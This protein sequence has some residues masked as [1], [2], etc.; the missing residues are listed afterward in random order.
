MN[1]TTVNESTRVVIERNERTWRLGN[2][3][4]RD[5]ALVLVIQRM[6]EDALLV[7]IRNLNDYHR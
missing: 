7:I 5:E 2:L 6:N 1:R 4:F 3:S